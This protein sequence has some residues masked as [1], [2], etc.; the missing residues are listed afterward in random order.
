MSISRRGFLLG[1]SAGT[2]AA[3]ATPRSLF[4]RGLLTEPALDELIKRA[5]AAAT[6]AGA[7][8]ADVR[9]VRMRHENLST[10]EDRIESVAS[11]EE[12]GVGVRVIAGGAWGFSATPNVI[13]TEAERIARHAVA[14]AKANASLMKNKVTLSPETPAVDVWQTPLIKDPFKIPLE[15]KAELLLAINREA[16]KVPGVKFVSS[17]YSAVAEWK[18]L[19]TTEGTYVEQEIVRLAPGYTVTAVNDKLGEFES[20]EHDFAA[21]Q[22]GW[23]YVEAAPLVADARRIAEEAVAKLKAPS[24]REGKHDLILDPSNLWLTIHESIGHPTE[25][26]RALGYEANF[27][28]TSF[29]TPDKLGKLR[30]GGPHINFYADK[31]TPGG[32]A[33]C[34]YDDDGVRTQKWNLVDKG[35]F[36]GYQTTREQAGW[37]NEKHSRGTCYGDSFSSFPFQR[38]PNVSLA[39]HSSERS[40]DDIVAA[41]DAGIVVTG[42]GSWSIDHQRLNFQFSGQTFWEVK[43]GKRTRMLRD[44][45]Y[46]ANTLEFWAGC[47]LIGGPKSWQLHGSMADGKGEPGQSNAV[48]HGCPP[49]RF[50]KVNIVNTNRRSA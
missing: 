43:G 29:A 2:L 3:L 32:L 30:I 11:N 22:A 24:V 42:R 4:A 38:M 49:A 46:Q 35:L 23:E 34:G 37:I 12:Y 14:I 36:V 10:R 18:L 27:A 5:L 15:D 9:I 31:T 13:A 44:L 20:R 41:T 6:K 47:D 1:A 45:A 48:S 7:S 8:Y 33:T 50:K 26:D 19:A 21:R 39:P 16:M 25:L 28:G 17:H 40:I